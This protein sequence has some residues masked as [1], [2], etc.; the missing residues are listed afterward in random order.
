[1]KFKRSA[2][3]RKLK[4]MDGFGTPVKMFFHRKDKEGKRETLDT[5]GSSVGGIVTMVY[6]ILMITYGIILF[7]NMVEGHNDTH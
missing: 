6:Y 7:V 5:Y 4:D 1:M 2:I 3:W